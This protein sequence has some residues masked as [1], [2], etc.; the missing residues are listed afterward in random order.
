MKCDYN[1]NNR[2]VYIEGKIQNM[3]PIEL[4]AHDELTLQLLMLL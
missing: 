2:D 3:P 4:H 1:C